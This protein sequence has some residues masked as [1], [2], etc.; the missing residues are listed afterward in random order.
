MRSPTLG[1]GTFSL[2][3]GLHAAPAAAQLR[4]T[5]VVSGLTLPVGFVQDPSDPTVQYVIEQG[6]RIRGVR[7]GTLQS[8]PFLDLT[9]SIAAGGERGLLGMALPP[10]CATSGR[11]YR[12]F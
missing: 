6:G 7:N 9:A 1:L 3:V 12:K 8:A 4:A 5:V 2:L 10:G 11:L